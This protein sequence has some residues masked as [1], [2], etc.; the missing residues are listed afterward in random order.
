MTEGDLD[1]SRPWALLRENAREAETYIVTIGTKREGDELIKG[2]L[3]PLEVL[4]LSNV[5][6]LM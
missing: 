1:S 2:R 3:C 4:S 6:F 5:G